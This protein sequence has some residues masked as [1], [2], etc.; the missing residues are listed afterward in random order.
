MQESVI[1]SDTFI[2]TSGCRI[3][4]NSNII[5]IDF[6]TTNQEGVK[7][8]N[9]FKIFGDVRNE[10]VQPTAFETDEDFHEIGPSDTAAWY[11][12]TYVMKGFKDCI[13]NGSSVTSTWL[14]S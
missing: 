3:P 11:Q 10:V 14:T 2:Y 5:V 6:R 12:S 4:R 9:D 7:C 1:S 8:C 13:V